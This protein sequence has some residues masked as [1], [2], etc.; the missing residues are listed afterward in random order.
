MNRYLERAEE[1]L[2]N[3]L[4]RGEITVQEYNAEMRELHAQ[5]QQWAEDQAQD[6][7]DRVMEDQGFG[8]Y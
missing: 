8:R 7:Y 6:A 5:F 1:E 4:E 3:Q 2:D